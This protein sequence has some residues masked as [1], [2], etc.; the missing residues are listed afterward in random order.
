MLVGGLVLVFSAV[1]AQ[2]GPGVEWSVIAGG[3]GASSSGAVMLNDTLG[4]PIVGPSPSGGGTALDA[5]YW[6]QAFAPAR[7]ADLRASKATGLLKLDWSAV[8]LDTGGHAIA[9][10]TYNVYHAADA[11]YFTPGA[12]YATGLTSPTFTDPDAGVI[13]NMAQD[14]YYVVRAVYNGLLAGPSNRAGAFA[15]GLMPGGP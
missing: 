13:G 11:P 1:S 14:T 6:Q 12:V 2:G 8:T 3:G 4:Q 9:G 7:I 10:V 5:G 15:F